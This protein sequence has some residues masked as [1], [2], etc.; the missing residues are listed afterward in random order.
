M[1]L[2]TILHCFYNVIFTKLNL[3]YICLQSN[4]R[5][6]KHRQSTRSLPDVANNRLLD[7]DAKWAALASGQLKISDYEQSKNGR[8]KEDVHQNKV[9]LFLLIYGEIVSDI[10]YP[11]VFFHRNYNHLENFLTMH[12]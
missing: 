4:G 3:I 10:S 1:P 2:F 11:K 9:R 8:L 7:E 6:V 5:N 12:M